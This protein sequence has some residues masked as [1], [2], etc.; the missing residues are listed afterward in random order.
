VGLLQL[1]HLVLYLAS[2]LVLL[3]LL[4]L[5]EKTNADAI[6]HLLI[7]SSIVPGDPVS[8]QQQP[9]QPLLARPALL[10]LQLHPALPPLL[11]GVHQLHEQDSEGLSL[12]PQPL[13]FAPEGLHFKH[14]LPGANLFG[15]LVPPT[16]FGHLED[17]GELVLA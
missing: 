2:T 1:L 17:C 7:N 13:A 14:L 10:L 6:T 4:Q 12:L 5:S 3:G 11:E 15:Q 9:P 16:R 8:G